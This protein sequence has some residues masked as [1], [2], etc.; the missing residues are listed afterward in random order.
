ME[1]PKSNSEK[2]KG[3]NFTFFSCK[4]ESGLCGCCI[5][6]AKWVTLWCMWPQSHGHFPWRQQGISDDG[7]GWKRSR[8]FFHDGQEL[9]GRTRERKFWEMAEMKMKLYRRWPRGSEPP[10]LQARQV[11]STPPGSIMVPGKQ[12]ALKHTR[13]WVPHHWIPRATKKWKWCQSPLT[14]L[15]TTSVASDSL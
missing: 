6:H 7:H 4:D 2:K 8:Q 13:V 5:P 9:G 14:P 12:Q 10:E 11:K 3:Q 1:G 15:V